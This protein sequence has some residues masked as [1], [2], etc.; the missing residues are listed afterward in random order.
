MGHLSV[1]KNLGLNDTE[2]H[3]YLTLLEK[4]ALQAPQVA[5]EAGTKRT[6]I[7]A[8][9]H[10]LCQL[11]IV[12]KI[13][14][15]KKHFY[16]AEKPHIVA[17]LFQEKLQSFESIIPFL[18]SME[19]K[20]TEVFGFQF[21]ETNHDLK[22]FFGRILVEYKNRDY[23]SFGDLHQWEKVDK[24]FFT[25]LQKDRARANIRNYSLFTIS[26]G[27]L[28]PTNPTL[29]KTSKYLPDK[30]ALNSYIDIFGDKIFVLSPSLS[31]LAVVITIPPL[32]E[33]FQS[34]FQIL[35]DMY[36]KK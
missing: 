13:T 8:I 22:E 12:T 30:Y 10:A 23:A 17:G 2:S 16:R 3:V 35:W 21:I 7:Y 33:M 11:G 14:E 1:I 36:S 20:N 32:V 31:S 9:L 34:V 29:L 27:P 15:K 18:E 25:Q 26:S 19:K 5:T 24:E 28:N 4:G 6:T